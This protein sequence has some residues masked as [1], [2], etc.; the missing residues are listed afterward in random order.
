MRVPLKLRRPVK[1]SSRLSG[2]W[3]VHHQGATVAVPVTNSFAK[4]ASTPTATSNVW[5]EASGTPVDNYWVAHAKVVAQN[6]CS[7]PPWT[8][9]S[10]SGPRPRRP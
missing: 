1:P 10:R 9:T 5:M 7:M 3:P 2:G 6:A 8:S 4:G